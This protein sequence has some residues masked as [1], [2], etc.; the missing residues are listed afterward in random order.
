[1]RICLVRVQSA[2]LDDDCQMALRA[3][4]GFGKGL[5]FD[6][7]HRSWYSRC[8]PERERERESKKTLL[9]N[10]C[11]L[12]AFVSSFGMAANKVSDSLGRFIRQE[13]ERTVHFEPN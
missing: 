1:M 6:E 8:G 12:T 5:V 13:R 11:L 7:G 3:L 4:L 10:P 9:S 2:W